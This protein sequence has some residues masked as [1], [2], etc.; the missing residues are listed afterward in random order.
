MQGTG[1]I[2]GGTVKIR[3]SGALA[4]ALNAR[5]IGLNLLRKHIELCSK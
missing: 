3:D 4:V 5:G 1:N 2:F